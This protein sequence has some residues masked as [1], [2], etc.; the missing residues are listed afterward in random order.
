MW[1]GISEKGKEQRKQEKRFRGEVK[2]TRRKSKQDFDD[3]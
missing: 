1:E 3:D 2:A